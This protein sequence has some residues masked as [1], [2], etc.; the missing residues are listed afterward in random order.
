VIL[1]STRAPR[2]PVATASAWRGC[3]LQPCPE[4]WSYELTERDRDE[5]RRALDCVRSRPLHAI[6]ALDFRLPTL[7][8]RLRR[9]ARDLIDGLGFGLLRGFPVDGLDTEDITPLYFGCLTHV[10]IPA[11]G[12]QTNRAL[13]YHSDSADLV[14][15]FC[16]RPAASGGLSRILSAVSVHN[17]ILKER[18]DLLAVL[19]NEPFYCSWSGQQPTGQPPYYWSRFYSWYRGRLHTSGIKERYVDEPPMTD[20]QRE[21]IAFVRH[22]LDRDED[23]LALTMDL[24]PGDVQ[25]LDNSVVWHSRTAFVDAADAV[26]RRY[27]LRIWLNLFDERPVAP[28]FGNRYEMVGQRTTSPKRRLF[29]VPVY[30]TW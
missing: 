2:Y 20:G 3:D 24:R 21:A 4:G 15:L 1:G 7:G 30:D 19:Y 13:G 14:S 23:V 5:V 17:T 27:L 18:P 9:L 22:V 16:V 29:G 11:R 8:P 6:S 25:I 12:Y 28:D 26:H 10:G